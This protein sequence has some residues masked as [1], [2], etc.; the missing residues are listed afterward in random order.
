[1]AARF[2]GDF[3]VTLLD[4][5]RNIRLESDL[6]FIDP[7]DVRWA[8]PKGAVVD[9]ASIPKGFWSIIGGPLEGKYRNASI[10]H[11]WFCDKR[12]RTWQATHRVFY[13]GMIASG[14][15]AVQAKL[16]YYAVLWGGPRWEERVSLN[17]NLS[18]SDAFGIAPS[19]PRMAT[20]VVALDS[21]G[22]GTS[23]A[24]QEA[25]AQRLQ[26][27]IEAQDLSLD[28]IEGLAEQAHPG[29]PGI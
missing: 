23:I 6:V 10:I 19:A 3:L 7:A 13:D 9:G 29:L 2:E 12:T 16:M 20:E 25:A 18:T 17:T 5:G 24:E 15:G 14:V 26:A 21:P 22:G 11:D 27:M 1:M 4:D 8:A 28:A